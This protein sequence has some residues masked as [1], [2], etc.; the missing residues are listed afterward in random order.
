MEM[1]KAGKVHYLEPHIFAATGAT[2]QGF[3]TRHEGISRQ[4]YNSLNLGTATQD[5]PHYVQGNR[6]ILARAFGTRVERLVTVTQV[7]GTD[8]LVIDTPN[9][10]YA[11]FLKIECDGLI[12][13]QPGVMI[14][15]SVADC[16]PILLL[17]PMKKVVAA[18]HAG[19]KGTA[20]EIGRKGVE[21]LVGMFGSRQADIL[22]AIG[23]AIGRC[24]YEVNAPV[25]EAFRKSGAGLECFE[26]KST[27]GNWRL[28]LVAANY[29]QLLA[30]G[31]SETNIETTP[32]CV[33][34]E[35]DLFFSYRRDGGETGRQMG[36][37][38]LKG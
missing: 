11:H 2:L 1:K 7:H 30:A 24:C 23:P 26:Q 33:S 37:I 29:G 18:L 12:T 28:D 10:D 3:T 21:A 35:H 20:G 9:P 4:P 38:K 15:V 8:L 13:N 32:L 14:G 31:L 27:P 22:A 6:S 36:F 17:D 16:V 25:M 34:C 19:W 5:Y